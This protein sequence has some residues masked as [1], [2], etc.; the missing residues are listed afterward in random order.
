MSSFEEVKATAIQ[1]ADEEGLINLKRP[2]L[3]E[4]AGIKDGSFQIIMGMSF[5]SFLEEIKPLCTNNRHQL[6]KG[7]AKGSVRIDQVL[8]L[9]LDLCEEVGLYH[10]TRL[11]LAE[12]CGVSPGLFYH[13]FGTMTQLRRQIIRK[14]IAVE[15]LAIIAQGLA[16]NDSHAK[17]APTELKDRA[18]ASLATA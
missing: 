5:T 14:A 4:R 10:V 12:R 15:R 13:H 9:A 6:K 1:M 18:I 17:K 3:C 7:R 2:A 16:L 8:E 11:E